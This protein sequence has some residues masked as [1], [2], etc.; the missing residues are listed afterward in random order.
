MS[1]LC[2]RPAVIATGVSSRTFKVLDKLPMGSQL[3]VKRKL[4]QIWMARH[5]V[6]KGGASCP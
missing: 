4:T 3:W 1:P 2:C 5:Q 6:G